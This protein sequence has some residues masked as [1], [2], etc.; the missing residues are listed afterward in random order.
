VLLSGTVFGFAITFCFFSDRTSL[1]LKE[2][3]QFDPIVFG[4]LMLVA[5][6]A[7]LATMSKPEKDLGFLNRDQTDE[8]KGWMQL[9]ILIYRELDVRPKLGGWELTFRGTKTTLVPP[10]SRVSTTPSEFSSP[11]T[12]FNLAM[13][14]SFIVRG[15]VAYSSRRRRN[16]LNPAL[17]YKKADFGFARVAAVLVRLNLLTVALVYVMGTDYLSYYF[18]PLVRHWS[19]STL[20]GIRC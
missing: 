20:Y 9:A 11:L 12:S 4:V 14:I 7:G 8:W 10:R 17:D 5:L 2:H 1:F 13:A 19:S 3:K 18:S 16:L 15:S 6:A